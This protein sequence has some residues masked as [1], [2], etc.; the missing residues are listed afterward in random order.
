VAIQLQDLITAA[1]DRHPA[2]FKTRVPSAT[3]AR[4]LSDYQNEL[5]GKAL[6]RDKQFLAQK[7]TVVLSLAGNSA[8]GTVAAGVGDGLPGTVSDAGVFSLTP[9][10]TGGLIEAIVDPAAGAQVLVSERVVSSATT[11]SLVATGAAWT[12]NLYVGRVVVITEGPG[13]GQRR[14]V[15]SNTVDTLVISTGADGLQWATTPT[16]KSLFEVVV[17]VYQS[18]GVAGV[19]TDLPATLTQTGYLVKLSA[20]GVPYIDYTAPLV[21]SVEAG[22]PLPTALAIL[23]GAARYTDADRRELALVSQGQRFDPPNWPA[24]YTVGQTLFLCGSKQDWLDVASLELDYVPIAPAFTQLTDY[25]LLPD[26]A[27][28]ALVAAAAGFMAERVAGMPDVSID[29]RALVARAAAAESDYLRALRLTRRGRRA[30]FR[31]VDY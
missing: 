20:T 28:P 2:F 30:Q 13:M 18:S 8:P 4:F 31:A 16:T 3:I 21:A 10:T 17:P 1:R 29:P 25:A 7:A 14:S 23:G 27:K 24:A 15:L 11:V 6:L 22:V 9:S 26:A 12:V 19:V 5:I